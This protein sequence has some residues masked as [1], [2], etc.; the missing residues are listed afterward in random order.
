[1]SAELEVSPESR[2]PKKTFCNK[3]WNK[4]KLYLTK[5]PEKLAK[6]KKTSCPL[7]NLAISQFQM[8]GTQQVVLATGMGHQK[9]LSPQVS[10]PRGVGGALVDHLHL[11]AYTEVLCLEA[12]KV[13]K[14]PS[15]LPEGMVDT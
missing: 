4:T 8:T 2:P 5:A 15:A 11:F 1:M 7:V 12:P 9:D 6:L 3:N 13:A 10:G 14:T